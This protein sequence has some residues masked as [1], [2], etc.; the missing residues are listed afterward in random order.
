MPLAT[1]PS[2]VILAAGEDNAS[3]LSLSSDSSL[4]E[5]QV[6]TFEKYIPQNDLN[7]IV[8]HNFSDIKDRFPNLSFLHAYDHKN[9]LQS[10]LSVQHNN[11]AGCI[12]MYGDTLFQ[13]E[14]IAH[15]L[16]AQGDC[17][18]VIDSEWQHRFQGR[19]SYDSSIAEVIKLGDGEKVEFTGLVKMNDKV[20]NWLKDFNKNTSKDINFVEAFNEIQNAGFSIN[21]LD[22]YGDWAE[23]NQ[24]E[25]LAH[26]VMGTKAE[27]LERLRDV[28]K[29]SHVCDQ[30]T[31]TADEW[32]NNQLVI[33]EKIQSLFHK[34]KIIIRS[35]SDLED[36][37]SSSN[38]GAF[39][40]VMD[41]D[42]TITSNVIEAIDYVISFYDSEDVSSQILVQNF[43]QDIAISGVVFTCD[44][45]TGAPY[46]VINYDDTS[47]KSD[48]ITSGSSDDIRTVVCLKSNLENIDKIDPRIESVITAVREI[49]YVLGYDRLDIEFAVDKAG[50]IFTFQVRP[51]VANTPTTVSE[52]DTILDSV[53]A[54]ITNFKFWQKPAPQILGEYACFSSMTDWNPAE[55]IGHNP[56]D[57]AVSLYRHLITEQ[58]WAIQRFEYGY[59]DVR[60]SPLVHM[61]CSHPYVDC[62]ASINSL[63]PS[64]LPEELASKLATIYLDRLVEEPHL[65]DKVE[66]ELVFTI[67]VQNFKEEF[68]NRFPNHGLSE[69][70]LELIENSLKKLTAAAFDR[71]NSDI[72]SIKILKEK[73]EQVRDSRCS[74]IQKIYQLIEDCRMHGTLAFS[75]AARA[76]FVSITF[77]NSLVKD[78]ILTEDR[79][80][81]FQR[82]IP[83]V[84]TE[85]QAD[86]CNELTSSKDLIQQYGHLRPGTY[87]INQLAYWE[88]PEF[89]F[90][91]PKTKQHTH[92][93][94]KFSDQEIR[95]IN[96]AISS[97]S[98]KLE[99]GQVIE[100]LKNS[101]SSKRKSK[102]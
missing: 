73:F 29:E 61:F 100:F 44:L 46:Y 34:Q 48:T 37:W 32:K 43:V 99:F 62:R 68:C 26:F 21:F 17:V 89:Y 56:N 86:L 13:D 27:T 22:V 83:T 5:W 102:I 38:A 40:S 50:T 35:S 1:I 33:V 85:F 19:T 14:T 30:V 92:E 6:H 95:G 47:G 96:S 74:P 8:A 67:W 36:G 81:E 93:N 45:T 2:I 66:L 10:F 24:P 65:H 58:N 75:H 39:E 76:G 60:P 70:D 15:L 57:L 53:D 98:K 87:D 79:M 78:G 3:L 42:S 25:D 55:I 90:K 9:A 11:P 51:I 4:L 54:A 18:V 69:D 41:V 82:S 63:I 72:S 91:R 16:E 101:N 94:F 97:I 64:D 84:T 28:L 7:V 31:F 20:I 49:E 80:L 52:L 88:N 23:M 12:S 59:R 71:L 77:L